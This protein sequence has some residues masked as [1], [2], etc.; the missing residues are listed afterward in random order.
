MQIVKREH[1]LWRLRIRSS[2]DLW[3]LSRLVGKGRLFAMLGER[4]DQT[5]GGVEGGR[6][7]AAERKKMWI[8]LHVESTEYQTFSDIL[9]VHGVITEAKIDKGSH[10]THLV[11]FGD[12]VEIS[13][14]AGFPSPDV[15]LL[16]EAVK[17]GGKPR[18]AIAAVEN[19]EV[20]LYELSQH[21]MRDV[22]AWTMR[23]GGKYTG[24]AN[25][26]VRTTFLRNIGKD[27]EMQLSE[28]TPLILSGP[29]M[30][31][32]QLM[33]M[34]RDEGATR[35]IASV[36]TSIGGRSS[37][38]EVLRE[39]LADNILCDYALVKEVKLLEDAW[40]RIATDGAVAYGDAELV[41]ALEMGAIETLLITADLLRDEDARIAG[42]PWQSYLDQLDAIRANWIQCSTEHDAGAQLEAFG[43]AVALL[44]FKLDD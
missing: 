36:A 11:N 13:C 3:T 39:G 27:M 40:R 34:M 25:T 5:T 16:K 26:D 22:A 21:G 2:D 20:A 4:R 41:T 1:D 24:S 35:Q 6:A 29:G 38:N 19:D 18:V 37:A 10:H 14:P 28:E 33:Q 30:A 8:Q 42:K 15:K 32:D 43:S 31:R 44:R 7:K 23:G 17:S 12:E 9:R